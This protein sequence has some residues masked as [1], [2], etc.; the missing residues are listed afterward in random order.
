MCFHDD[1]ASFMLSILETLTKHHIEYHTK[2][3][4]LVSAVVGRDE[5]PIKAGLAAQLDTDDGREAYFHRLQLDE[6]PVQ[7]AI[8]AAA[9]VCGAPALSG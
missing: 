3:I 6:L 4:H 8:P 5:S 2:W 7:S 9:V 1:A